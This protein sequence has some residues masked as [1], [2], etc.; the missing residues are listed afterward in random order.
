MG[1]VYKDRLSWTAF[2]PDTGRFYHREL[3]GASPVNMQGGMPGAVFT[4]FYHPTGETGEKELE[5]CSNMGEWW[6]A[7][8]EQ[9]DATRVQI[10]PKGKTREHRL[11]GETDV[12]IFFDATVEVCRSVTIVDA[13]VSIL[14]SHEVVRVGENEERG[15]RLV[16]ITD[17]TSHNRLSRGGPMG[18]F[19]HTTFTNRLPPELLE[20]PTEGTY[21]SLR[22]LRLKVNSN[23]HIEIDLFEAKWTQLSL[24]ECDNFPTVQAL[25]EYAYKNHIP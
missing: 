5:Y 23:G 2:N 3:K 22:N 11:I 20:N 4:P 13:I 14:S 18:A 7:L 25:L 15:Q 6:R 16:L 17:Y 9:A 12:D 1:V 10:L 21:W 8:Q 19:G 24:D